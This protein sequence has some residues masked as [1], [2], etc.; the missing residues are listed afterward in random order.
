MVLTDYTFQ[1]K[2]PEIDTISSIFNKNVY[3]TNDIEID[4]EGGMNNQKIKNAIK[5]FNEV[6]KPM[7]IKKKLKLSLTFKENIKLIN[8]NRKITKILTAFEK[9]DNLEG[10][11][12]NFKNNYENILR[13]LNDEMDKIKASIKMIKREDIFSYMKKDDFINNIKVVFENENI[14]FFSNEIP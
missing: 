7:D 12:I 14:N 8:I 1:L 2:E 11:V 10:K 5:Y 13:Q 6:R 4:Q 9:I 3:N